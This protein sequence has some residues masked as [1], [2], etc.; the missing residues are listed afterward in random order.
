MKPED[1]EARANLAAEVERI[2]AREAAGEIPAMMT[3]QEMHAAAT[4]GQNVLSV[5]ELIAE[6]MPIIASMAARVEK[7]VKQIDGWLSKHVID[8]CD[9]HEETPLPINRDRTLMS[10]FRAGSLVV[11]YDTCPKCKARAEQFVVNKRWRDMGIPAKVVHATFHNFE[12]KGFDIRERAKMLTIKQAERK[13]G[14]LIL[15]GKFGTGK[16]HMAAAVLKAE[17]R[18]IFVTEADLVLELRTCYE[19]NKGQDAMIDKYREAKVLVIDELTTEIKGVDI[20]ALLYRILAHRY[21]EGLL[22]VITSNETLEVIMDI[23]GPRLV[24]R[25][26]EDYKVATFDW[27]SHRKSV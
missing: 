15:R 25:I 19:T 22:S 6:A 9:E 12:T 4:A 8:M 13:R 21:D 23:L 5:G 18:G 20:P 27:E 2:K 26:K 11:E 17:G 7:Q 16:S 1:D 10:S 3:Q 24:D 14:F